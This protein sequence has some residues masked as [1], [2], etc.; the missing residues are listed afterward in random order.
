MTF[1]GNFKK[2]SKGP[3][4]SVKDCQ[5]T[6]FNDI[7]YTFKFIE[8]SKT[9]QK[10]KTVKKRNFLNFL[11]V[12]RCAILYHYYNLKNV[13]KTHGGAL[14]LVKLQAEACNFAKSN[15]TPWVFFMF[16]KLY[17]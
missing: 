2:N 12:M 7:F 16:F 8:L 13:K 9:V 11:N 3:H 4:F 6:K 14:L 15:T 5:I 17:K 10:K 1:S